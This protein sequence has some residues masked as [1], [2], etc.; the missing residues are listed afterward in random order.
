MADDDAAQPMI[1]WAN[2]VPPADLAVELMP[3][4]APSGPR[5]GF[6]NVVARVSLVR[7]LF[8]AYPKLNDFQI[9]RYEKELDMPVRE[10]MQLLEHAELVYANWDTAGKPYWS[11]T[12]LGLAALDSGRV[13]VRQR[14]KD[15]TGL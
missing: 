5:A 14:I 10:A 15:R 7:W 2:S 13:A 1:D 8:R 6:Y 9:S 12:R 11:P 4:F 3:A